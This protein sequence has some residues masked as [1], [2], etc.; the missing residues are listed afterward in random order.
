MT[1]DDHAQSPG[2]VGGGDSDAAGEPL[3][4]RCWNCGSPL[5]EG[6]MFCG[7]CG[8]AA[9]QRTVRPGDADVPGDDTPRAE[10][11]GPQSSTGENDAGTPPH[12]DALVEAP[13]RGHGAEPEEPDAEDDSAER[14]PDQDDAGTPP[15]GDALIGSPAADAPGEAPREAP[16]EDIPDSAPT[17]VQPVLADAERP[18][19]DPDADVDVD[20]D[21][22][23]D[24][25]ADPLAPLTPE[26]RF[27]AE[28]LLDP[29]SQADK[30]VLQFSTGESATVYGSGLVGR[31]PIAEPGEYVDHFVVI[32]DP[33]RSVSKTHLE[34]GQD[35]GA[36][37]VLDRFSGN[38]SVL[39]EP[40]GQPKR[41]EP[42]RRYFVVRG[43]RIEIGD[44]FFVLS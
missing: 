25:G 37:W 36:F 27:A 11:A 44:Q 33:G 2:S 40:D 30:F 10:P 34:F 15:H 16:G 13:T 6:A 29:E 9:G 5:P 7:E 1:A 41:C 32:R 20:A 38:G 19:P 22:D 31:N 21:A 28:R 12:G 8:S 43:T 18:V 4:Q 23:A 42:G 14:S 26:E 3:G 17:E 35:N 24:A 39:R